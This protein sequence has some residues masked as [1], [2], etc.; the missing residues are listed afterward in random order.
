MPERILDAP[1]VMDDFHLNLVDWSENNVMAVALGGSVYL[2]NAC[3]HFLISSLFT[4]F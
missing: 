3:E 4:R 1:G 2:W